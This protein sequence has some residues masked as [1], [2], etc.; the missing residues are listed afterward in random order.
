MKPW[1]LTLLI[2]F[3]VATHVSAQQMI[4]VDYSTGQLWHLYS[5]NGESK[6]DSYQI[7]LP[8]I[9]VQQEMNLSRPVIGTLK[10]A[11]Y[12]PTWWPTA[13]MRRKNKALPKQVRYGQHGHP[14]GIYRLQITWHN[15]IDSDFWQSVRIHGNAKQADLNEA[16]SAGC[17]RMLDEDIKQMVGNIEAAQ[18]QGEKEVQVSFGFFS[19]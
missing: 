4:T 7:V 18:R 2:F 16:E 12:K 19:G 13:N 1:S 9:R 14:I 3:G 5:L 15:P 6:T 8:K 17:V 11:D 10:Q